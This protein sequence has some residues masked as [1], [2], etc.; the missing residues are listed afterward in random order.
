M[1]GPKRPFF[2]EL[3]D[4]RFPSFQSISGILPSDSEFHFDNKTQQVRIL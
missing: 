2:G 3:Y 4:Q 1:K